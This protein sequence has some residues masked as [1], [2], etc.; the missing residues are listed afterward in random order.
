[1]FDFLKKPC[2]PSPERL[3]RLTDG[4]KTYLASAYQPTLPQ[5][6]TQDTPPAVDDGIRYS[7][8]TP[9]PEQMMA[10][11]IR[12][13]DREGLFSYMEVMRERSFVEKV[14]EHIREKGVKDSAV[15]KAAGIDRRLFSKMMSD[16]RYRP[17]KDTAVAMA[18]GLR[19]TLS[20][21]E[22]LLNRA[23][24]TLSRSDR[25][26]VLLEYFFKTGTYDLMEIN[27][28]LSAFG[29]RVL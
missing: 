3:H 23:G 2:P 20:G 7:E 24:F 4:A 28:V 17:S 19:L 12:D 25:R 15:Y 9:S 22:D 8:R 5:L 13:G 29:E 10:E 11:F 6:K 1:M 14:Q 26:D 21:A 27:G 18:F 16:V